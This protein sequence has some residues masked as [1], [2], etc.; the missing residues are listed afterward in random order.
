[1]AWS[2]GLVIGALVV[3]VAGMAWLLAILA[4]RLLAEARAG[5]AAALARLTELPCGVPDGTIRALISCF[6]II[7]G[8]LLIGLQKPLGLASAEALTGFIGAVIS[9]YFVTRSAETRPGTAPP[10]ASP[11]AGQAASGSTALAAARGV[12]DAAGVAT[13]LAARLAPGSALAQRA[14]AATAGAREVLDA[15]AA[16]LHGGNAAAIAGV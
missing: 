11:D 3:F 6:I 7:F 16:A 2:V 12:L 5:G 1:M 8:F 14:E 15:T 13:G 9:F 10:A 4:G